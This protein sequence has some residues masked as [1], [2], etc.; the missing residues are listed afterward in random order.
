MGIWDKENKEKPRGRCP[1]CGS[2]YIEVE[3]LDEKSQ[4]IY[5]CNRCRK[6]F[7]EKY[8]KVMFTVFR[9]QQVFA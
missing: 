9:F 3:S 1:Y 7:Q 6:Q 4:V 8:M 5:R 2:Y